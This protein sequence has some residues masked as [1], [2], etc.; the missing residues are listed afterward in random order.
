MVYHA[1]NIE[2]GH[3]HTARKNF[4]R[5]GNLLRKEVSLTHCSTWTAKSQK[6]YNHDEGKREARN[7]SHKAEERRNERGT[8]QTH[9]N[10]RS[11]ENSPLLEEP[12]L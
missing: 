7:L 2:L 9:R 8:C 4:P 5:L 6:T 1:F 3:F 12:L 11:H 10:I